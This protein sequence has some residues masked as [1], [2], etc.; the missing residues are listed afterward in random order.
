MIRRHEFQKDSKGKYRNKRTTQTYE[1]KTEK[2]LEI[3]L[4]YHKKGHKTG[5]Y[6]IALQVFSAE[7]RLDPALI[8]VLGYPGYTCQAQLISLRSVIV[9]RMLVLRAFSLNV[10]FIDV[11]FHCRIR[12]CTSSTMDIVMVQCY[13]KEMIT[14]RIIVSLAYEE[15][16]SRHP[17]HC[18]SYC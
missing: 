5:Q 7:G 12:T 18:P 4:S 6:K 9:I 3:L 17:K 13:E 14:D 2:E 10:P 15:E 8:S 16:L 11:T 1:D